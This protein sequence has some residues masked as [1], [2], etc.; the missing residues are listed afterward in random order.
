M[1]E[2]LNLILLSL[3]CYRIASLISLDEGPF[4]IFH[5]LRVV[6][7]AYDYGQNGKAGS[8]LGRGIAC[9]YCVGLWIALPLALYADLSLW[10]L[11]WLAIAGMQA[12]LQSISND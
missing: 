8:P 10:W 2:W 12:F 7:G 5:R 4:E 3:V 1:N 9:P 11:W 6:S